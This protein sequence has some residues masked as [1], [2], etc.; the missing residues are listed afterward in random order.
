M[1]AYNKL[2]TTR[3]EKPIYSGISST[4]NPEI[5]YFVVAIQFSVAISIAQLST[6]SH[7]TTVA[8]PKPVPSISHL[9]LFYF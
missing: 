2:L 1:A 7:L 5:G 8:T 6:M 9:K 4:E 3:A